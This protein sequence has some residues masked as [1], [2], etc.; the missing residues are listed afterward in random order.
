MTTK[1]VVEA[2]AALEHEQWVTW[3]KNLIET[4]PDLSPVRRRR[5][6]EFF[7]PYDQLDEE[8]KDQDRKWARKALRIVKSH[9]G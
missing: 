6:A 8:T 7:V 3:A 4:E 9:L 2:L 1:E 5:W